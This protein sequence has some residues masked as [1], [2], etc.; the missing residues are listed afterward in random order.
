MTNPSVYV[1]LLNWNGL[2]DTLECLASLRVQ[3]YQPLKTIVV[4]NGSAADEASVIASQYPEVKVLKQGRNLGFCGGNNVGIRDALAAGADN[5]LVLNN[6]TIV[7]A[8]LIS[9][10][11]RERDRLNNVGAV[12]PV[13]LCHPKTDLI[14]YAG[15]VWEAR[16]AGFRH[17]LNYE[18]RSKLNIQ[19]PFS[20]EYACGCCLLISASVLGKVGLMDERYFAYYDEADWSSRMKQAGLGCYVI[21]TASLY[22]KVSRTTPGLMMSYL[23]ARNRL[24]WMKEHLPWRERLRSYPYL[25]KEVIW[26]LCN[27]GGI[28]LKRRGPSAAES[29]AMLIALRDF[30]RGR[31]GAAPASI[32]RLADQRNTGQTVEASAD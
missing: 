27:L 6:D 5:V 15:S 20:T 3:D 7:P 25:C 12:S 4:D 13:I 24:L 28:H 19:E 9:E 8:Q 18:S 10:L 21:P 32:T 1:V 22:H 2:A 29:K 16:T 14:W 31:F 30:L 17:P 11:M 23:M 26:N